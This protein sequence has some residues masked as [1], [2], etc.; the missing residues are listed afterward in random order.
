[1]N[2]RNRVQLIGN[3]GANP[4]VREFGKDK[5]IARFSVATTDVSRKD[6]K[7]EKHTQWHSIVVWD[8]LADIAEQNLKTGTEV[9]VDGRIV[10]R[11][12]VDESG[13]KKNLVEIVA[14]KMLFRNRKESESIA[15]QS[16]SKKRA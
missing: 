11:S 5:K 4:I 10:K 8:K 6:G 15:Q 13:V 7:I 14:D 1:M 2:L 3:L 16:A 12:Y 9:V